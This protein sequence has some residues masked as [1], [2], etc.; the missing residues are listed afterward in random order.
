[1]FYLYLKR[2]NNELKIKP[3]LHSGKKHGLEEEIMEQLLQ[4]EPSLLVILD[5]GAN[6]VKQC[7]QLKELGWSIV[8]GEHH[9]SEVENPYA[10]L[11]SNQNSKK[12]TNKNLCGTGVG[13]KLM[14]AIDDKLGKQYAKEFISYVW[15]ANVADSMLF[16][17]AE[18]YTFAK[19]GR[20]YIHKNLQPFVDEFCEGE[21]DNKSIAWGLVPKFNATIRLGT[22]KE[23]E[24]LFNAMCGIGDIE[25]TIRMCKGLHS[26]QSNQSKKMVEDV[27]IVSNEQIVIGKMKESSAMTGLIAGKL[28]SKYNK[29]VLLVH[30]KDGEMSGSVRSPIPTKDVFNKSGL[31]TFNQG[32][33][34]AHGTSYPL[35]NQQKI[36]EYTNDALSDLEPCIDVLASTTIKDIPSRL[37]VLTEAYK[38]VY[39]KGIDIPT[40]HIKPFTIYNTDIQ[41]LGRG[42][43]LK[44]YKN[45]IEFMMFFVSKEKKERLF[46]DKKKR[47]IELECIVE[48]GI[49]EWNGNK[50]MQAIIK[51][52]ECREI[53]EE[54]VDWEDIW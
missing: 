52:F 4:V 2:I 34:Y 50:K 40:Y 1:M 26:K 16:T 36:I 48:L 23:K 3:L 39:G 14:Q 47:K 5:A 46:L 24:M 6:D 53:K 37:F 41:E 45:G 13:F 10:I 49:N 54:K 9:H 8:I 31:F 27:E 32:H 51:E 42:T 22:M 11:I 15:M 18:N 43:T 38:H 44:I 7:K 33:L 35:K 30:E 28:M 12:V 29:P 19:W 25:E 20:K 21:L 17:H